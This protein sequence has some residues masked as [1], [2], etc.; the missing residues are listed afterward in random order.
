[1]RHFLGISLLMA[2]VLS[3]STSVLSQS[4]NVER[5][6]EIQIGQSISGVIPGDGSSFN[7][8]G[9]FVVHRFDAQEGVRYLIALESIE[10]YP[11][12]HVLT[13]TKG[14]TEIFDSREGDYHEGGEPIHAQIR[15]LAP[16][17]DTYLIVAQAYEEEGGSYQLSIQELPPPPPPT[18][19][20]IAVGANVTSVLDDNSPVH[21]TDWGAET[22]QHLY[23]IELQAGQRI[24]INMESDDFDSY[25]EFGPLTGTDID[26]TMVNDDGG[27]DLNARLRIS[28]SIDGTYGIRARTYSGYGEGT[29][30]L[31]IDPL[32]PARPAVAIPVTIGSGVSG[33]LNNNSPLHITEWGDEVKQDLYSIELASGQQIEINMESTDF[34]SYLEFGPLHNNNLEVTMTDDDS[35]GNLNARLRFDGGR[36]GGTFGIRAR[37]LS[38]YGEGAYTLRVEEYVPAPIVSN[39]IAPGRTIEG[40]LGSSDGLSPRGT[41]TQ[42]WTFTGRQGQQVIINLQSEDFDAYLYLGTGSGDNFV[43]L[44]YDDDGGDGWLDSRIEFVLPHSGEFTI[45]ATSF[46]SG[47]E[48]AYTLSFELGD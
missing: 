21:V 25:L 14:L 20:P 12:V 47:A 44:T 37:A 38:E 30:T 8:A 31:R 45:L 19:V 48:G 13:M 3:N 4:N 46:G 16:E 6:P 41:Y 39:E 26:I 22:K 33:E 24:E 7:W 35:G 1:M 40:H 28:V 17:T 34:D 15:F 10:I 27:E 32:E 43:E 11:L 2:F 5:F 42:A 18:V 36:N 23:G 9:P 29:Y